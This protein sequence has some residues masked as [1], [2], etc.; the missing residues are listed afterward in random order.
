VINFFLSFVLITVMFALIYKVMPQARVRWRDVWVGATTTSMLF[1][2]GKEAIGLYL[3]R[4][5]T[6]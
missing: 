2:A 4:S 3:G 5:G 1:T 6:V